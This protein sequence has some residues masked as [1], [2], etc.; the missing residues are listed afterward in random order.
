MNIFHLSFLNFEGHICCEINIIS[1]KITEL[2]IPKKIK[3]Q[4][5]LRSHLIFSNDDI[6]SIIHVLS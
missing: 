1:Q 4:K 2:V 6:N 5:V 3:L